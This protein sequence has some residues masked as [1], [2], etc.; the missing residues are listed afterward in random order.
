[1]QSKFQIG[2]VAVSD[3]I[4]ENLLGVVSQAVRSASIKNYYNEISSAYLFSGHGV[5]EGRGKR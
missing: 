4:E 1:M 2:R 5:T 3:A